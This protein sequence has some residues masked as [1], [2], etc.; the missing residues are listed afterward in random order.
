MPQEAW[1]RGNAKAAGCGVRDEHGGGGA[2]VAA[3][4]SCSGVQGERAL[5]RG[6][7]ELGRPSSVGR[8][9]FLKQIF[10]N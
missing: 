2:V 8:N 10:R 3:A 6:L 1:A 7:A 9:V 5:G 4:V